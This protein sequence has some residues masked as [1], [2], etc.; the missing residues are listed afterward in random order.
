MNIVKVIDGLKNC[1][2]GKEHTV[3]IKAVEI[4]RG[5][6]NKT[7][8]ILTQNNFPQKILVVADKNTLKASDGILEILAQGGFGVKLKLY[9]NLHVA[10]IEVDRQLVDEGVLYHPCMRHKITLMRLIPMTDFNIE[11]LKPYYC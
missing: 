5:L 2:C 6:K 3:D 11:K 1:R 4:G 7:A 9:E 8:D 10:D